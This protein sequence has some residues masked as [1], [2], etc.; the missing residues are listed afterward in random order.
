MKKLVALE[1]IKGM[2][3]GIIYAEKHDQL[4][5]IKDHDH[6][7]GFYRNLRTKEPFH[8]RKEKI[9]FIEQ[10]DIF[11]FVETEEKHQNSTKRKKSAGNINQ[12]EL[13]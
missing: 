6:E 12:H 11:L 1:K 4:E 13:F 8:A 2:F 10:S 5:F 3:S 7:I 9:G